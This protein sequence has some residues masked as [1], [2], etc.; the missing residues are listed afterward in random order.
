[1]DQEALESLV[2]EVLG[3]DYRAL[4]IA[5]YNLTEDIREEKATIVCL[6]TGATAGE[7]KGRA[8]EGTGVGMVDA[9]FRGLQQSLSEDYPSLN[10]IRFVDFA[11]TGDFSDG[12]A[13]RTDAVGLVR[14]E[15]ENSSGRRF[16][17]GHQSH[18]I[19]ASSVGVVLKA[20]EHFVNAELAV[21]KVLD[22][23]D[24]AR[25]RQRADLAEKYTHRLADLVQ[26]AS[27]S[28]SI[29]RRKQASGL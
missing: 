7:E 8:V 28:E 10:H 6:L 23:I 5:R 24:D 29:E 2:R 9:L 20:V 22:W 16:D 15:V 27:Y 11:I 14:L 13:A 18:S 17:F 3:T 12:N 1:M 26:N 21:H 4:D 25:R 19:S